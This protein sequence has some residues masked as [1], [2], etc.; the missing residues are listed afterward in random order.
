MSKKSKDI[1]KQLEEAK[2]KTKDPKIIK[3]I[4]EK[5]QYV[6]KPVFK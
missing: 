4:E 3:A 5:Q 6:N 2:A 1:E